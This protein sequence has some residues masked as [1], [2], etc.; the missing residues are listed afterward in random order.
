VRDPDQ[1]EHVGLVDPAQVVGGDIGRCDPAADD[2]GIVDQ[3]VEVTRRVLDGLHGS[4][5]RG[6]VGDVEQHER[7]A[8]RLGGTLP[9][10]GI[11]SAQ[12]HGVA[13]RDE[14]AGRLEAKALVA[15]GDQGIG[16]DSNDART[17]PT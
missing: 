9:A 15:A 16:H 1:P 6:V 11:P 12:V 13:G 17:G 4:G 8:E 3:D 2:A 10:L 14:T 7:S 5:D